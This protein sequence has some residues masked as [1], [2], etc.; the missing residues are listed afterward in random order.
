MMRFGGIT[1]QEF[2]DSFWQRRFLL[3]RDSGC[4]QPGIS[5][6]Q[7]INLACEGAAESRLVLVDEHTREW[8]CE[9]GPFSA[10]RFDQLPQRGWTLLIQAVDQWLP[11][12]AALKR[13]FDFLPYWRLDDVMISISAIDGGVGP[14]FDSYDVFLL[15]TAGTRR[16]QI[17]Q[18]GDESTPLLDHPELKLMANF[19]PVQTYHLGVGDML[20]LPPGI[21]HWGSATSDD[22]MTCS[23]GFRAPS[24]AEVAQHA[25][26]LS[27]TAQNGR[28][29]DDPCEPNT[30]PYLIPESI[31]SRLK[32]AWLR[33]GAERFYALLPEAFGREVT[34]P[35][36]GELVEPESLPSADS[37]RRKWATVES[38]DVRH[39]PSS[40]FAYR[41]TAGQAQL[42]VDGEAY[43]TSVRFARGACHGRLA[44]PHD[45]DEAALLLSLLRDGSLFL[46]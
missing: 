29:A 2:L 1:Q 8:H 32:Q 13:A 12:V 4:P 37:L 14:H 3:I 46:F 21:S 31:E 15:Q 26:A 20:Y 5:P 39:H 17:G 23:I 27:E 6:D 24:Y 40:R 30:D 36:Y 41:L 34:E 22:C 19:A 10:S 35:R 11:Q 45:D 25:L 16:W 7:L 9:H 28:F 38:I 18:P 44:P 33:N 43:L 42:F